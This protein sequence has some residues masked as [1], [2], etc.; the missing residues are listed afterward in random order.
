M[1]H[2]FF[3]EPARIQNNA[4]V[5]ADAQARQIRDVLRMRVG[6]QVIALDN[7]GNEYRVT[8]REISRAIVRGEIIERCAARGEPSTKIILYQALLKA[9]KFEW[10]LQKGTEVGIVEFVPISTTRAIAD[11]VS[12][13]KSA[14]WTQ[15]V[16]E[17][18]EQAGRGKLPS[19]AALETFDAALQT[20]H[21]AGGQIFVFWESETPLD[22]RRALDDAGNADT[23]HLFVGPE[24]GFTPQEVE[25]ARIIGAQSLTLGPRILRAETAAVVAA[26]A[27][28]FARGDLS[29]T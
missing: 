13:Q 5:F 29:R 25:T 18:A 1:A 16:T 12:K 6:E 15:V 21:T 10:V 24:G 19:L 26:S 14:R 23:F 2:R 28:F 17:A 8:L 22:L 4:L 20:A 3:V 11:A 27:I 9:D 7:A